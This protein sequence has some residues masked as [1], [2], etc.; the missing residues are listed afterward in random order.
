LV[1]SAEELSKKIQPDLDK[2]VLC[3]SDIHAGNIL[4]ANEESIYIIDWDEPMLAPK[5]RDLMFI[6][7]GIGNVWNKNHE[8]HYFYEGYGKANV[9]KIMLSY[10][11]H[12]RIVQDIAEFGQI[13]LSRGQNDQFRL[14]SLK[15]FKA[16]FD[17]N[18]VVEIAFATTLMNNKK[19]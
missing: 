8:I 14:E 6:G 5:E 4:V 10:Y 11:R 16:M 9:D 12:E 1:D 18:N 15:H 17:P 19:Y 2:Y 3:H 13:L 7:G